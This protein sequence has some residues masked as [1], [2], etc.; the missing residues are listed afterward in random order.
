[1][2]GVDVDKAR[3]QDW[4]WDRRCGWAKVRVVGGGLLFCEIEKKSVLKWVEN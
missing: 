1:M 2:G 3:N 4:R